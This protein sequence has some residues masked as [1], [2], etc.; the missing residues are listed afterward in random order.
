MNTKTFFNEL[1]AKLKEK[2]FI[3]IEKIIKFKIKNFENDENLKFLL[4]LSLL[5][6]N[7]FAEADL[8]KLYDKKYTP[9]DR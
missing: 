8:H 9:H 7:K 2:N 5:Q 4:G 3:E 6:Q 1:E